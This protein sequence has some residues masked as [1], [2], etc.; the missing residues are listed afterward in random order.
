MSNESK[1]QILYLDT[2]SFP[3]EREAE[4]GA[5]R[6]AG[7]EVVIATSSANQYESYKIPHIIETALGDYANAKQTIVEYIISN[8]LNIKGV[9]AW[10]DNVVELAAIIGNELE[11]PCSSRESSQNARNK[12]NTR[13]ILEQ[14]NFVNPKYAA[15]ANHQ[16]FQEALSDIGV[17]CL[18]KPAGASFGRGIFKIDSLKDADLIFTD[19]IEYCSPSRDE[20]Y[21]YFRDKF[22]LE[23]Y[24]DG[25]EHSVAGMVANGEVYILA[26]A[27][28][29]IDKSIP[30]QY[31]NIVPSKLSDS[32]KNQV[33]DLA[34]SAV[35]LLGINWC[36]F[37]ID[38][39][40][41]NNGIPKILEIGGRL[42]G[43]A[44]NSHLIPLSTNSVYPYDLILQVVQGSNPFKK[45]NF[46]NDTP[47]QAGLRAF[48]PKSL[49]KIVYLEGFEKVRNHPKTKNFIQLKEINDILVLPSDGLGQFA[50]GY[51]VASCTKDEDLEEILSEI[52]SF[53]KVEVE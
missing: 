41:N 7:L 25:T 44:I 53:I 2:R 37:H 11:L 3:L 49:G 43:E 12:V 9:V 50:I 39:I 26:I 1:E 27:D 16:D 10:G 51:V 8:N 34:E 33:V 30:F 29:K 32:T 6:K 15:I 23:E 22:L 17:P 28:K 13:K 52:D 35:K 14:L 18:L 38:F 46:I 36:G 5:A 4:I 45:K 24:L 40:V 20:I 19:F 42:G 48:T 21:S 47:F 31:Q